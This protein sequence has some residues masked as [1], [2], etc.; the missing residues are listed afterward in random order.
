MRGDLMMGECFRWRGIGFKKATNMGDVEYVARLSNQAMF[1][2]I[3][4]P[5]GY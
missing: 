3:L 2:F 1:S 4:S 5:S